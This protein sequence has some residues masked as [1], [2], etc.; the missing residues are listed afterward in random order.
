MI[1]ISIVTGQF[2]ERICMIVGVNTVVGSIQRNSRGLE[3][4][5]S[6]ANKNP[7]TKGRRP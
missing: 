7:D 1:K 2:I 4:V 6:I 3:G 5:D